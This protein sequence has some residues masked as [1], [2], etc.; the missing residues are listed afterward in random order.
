MDSN[1]REEL[2][3]LVGSLGWRLFVDHVNSEWGAAGKAF[4]AA[5]TQAANSTDNATAMAHLQQVIVARREIQK[6]LTWPQE[7][8]KQL[9]APELVPAVPDFSRRG[10][11]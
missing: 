10:N 1:V 7:Q 6:L 9:K 5:V 8:L 4:D 2:D 3:A 11:L